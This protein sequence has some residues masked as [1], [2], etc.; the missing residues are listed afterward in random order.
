MKEREIQEDAYAKAKAEVSSAPLYTHQES[1][2]DAVKNSA[3]PKPDMV[4]T[5]IHIYTNRGSQKKK[6]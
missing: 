6:G 5:Y 2:L 1:S 4:C 3:E